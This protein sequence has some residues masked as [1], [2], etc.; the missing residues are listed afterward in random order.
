MKLFE[1][2]VAAALVSLA[3]IALA[4][5]V[6]QTTHASPIADETGLSGQVMPLGGVVSSRSNLAVSSD[7]KRIGS[8]Y[9]LSSRETRMIGGVLGQV[10]YTLVP[11]RLSLYAGTP[12]SALADGEIALELGTR[13]LVDRVGLLTAAVIPVTVTDSEAWSDPFVVDVPREATDVDR[14]GLRLGLAGIAGT[15]L[16]VDYRLYRRNVDEERSG[17][18][19]GLSPADRR[20]LA[21]DG[22]EHRFDLNYRLA[23]SD[24]LSLTPGVQYR[25]LDA[26]GAA[27]RGWLLR[28]QLSAQLDIARWQF[29]MTGYYGVDRYDAR[30]P[31]YDEYRDGNQM[32][33]MAGV[34]YAE[35][36]GWSNWSVNAYG[37]WSERDSDIRFYDERTGLFAVGLGYRF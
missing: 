29:S 7:Q 18:A 2:Y 13:Y 3:P 23:I 4:L 20:R 24:H 28:P 34:R 14:R 37:V 6:S 10:D 35:P 36:F 27:N 30:Q 22:N 9:S 11:R 1:K 16:S 12:R 26:D 32:G 33:V 8:L 25:R 31:I 21:R 5:G 17:V 19:L 15:G